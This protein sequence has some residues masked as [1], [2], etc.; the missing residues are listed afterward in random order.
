M[1]IAVA[2]TLLCLLELSTVA[3]AAPRRHH[4]KHPHRLTVRHHCTHPGDFALTFD[5]GPHPYTSQVLD[6]LKSQN[7]PATFFINGD[8]GFGH[9]LQYTNELKR[10]LKEGH[11]IAHHTYSHPNLVTEVKGEEDLADEV[12][13]LERELVRL[14][15]V[16]PAYFRAPYGAITERQVEVMAQFGFHAVVKWNIDSEDYNHPDLTPSNIN[17]SLAHYQT[18]LSNASPQTHSFIA[19]NH[20]VQPVTANVEGGSDFLVRVV[21]LVREKGYRKVD[22]DDLQVPTPIH[23]ANLPSR[24]TTPPPP[25]AMNDRGNYRRHAFDMNFD[26]LGSDPDSP[27]RP[28][29]HVYLNDAVNEQVSAGVADDMVQADVSRVLIIYTGGTIGMKN[30]PQHGYTPCPG[31]LSRTLASMVRFHD[32]TGFGFAS[33]EPEK[34]NIQSPYSSLTNPVNIVVRYPDNTPGPGATAIGTPAVSATTT[35]RSMSGGESGT[36]YEEPGV[37]SPT[38]RN[39]ASGSANH[40]VINGT[41]VVRSRKPVSILNVA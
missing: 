37:K 41:P 23:S 29:P 15:G 24:A 40:F 38:K 31:Y 6:I 25:L 10:M 3:S 20:D 12:F 16:A 9:V 39:A 28:D 1:L 13:R 4:H 22:H 5:D 36:S 35:S 27:P 21:E 2:S 18:A 30:T 11:Q 7:V 34:R 8:S 14:V 33:L 32:P 26:S 17:L 19:L